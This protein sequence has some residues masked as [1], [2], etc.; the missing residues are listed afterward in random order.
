MLILVVILKADPKS[1]VRMP[2]TAEIALFKEAITVKHSLLVDCYCMV[3]GLKLYL[4]QPGDSIIQTCF[5]NGWKHDY[6]VTT[7][8]AFA[9]NG[10]IIACTLNAPGTWHGST[11]PHWGSMYSKLQKY[12][13]D[14]HGKVLMDSAFASNMYKFIIQSSQNVPIME[15]HQAML[16]GQQA[17]SCR[18]AA[19]WG[20]R[21]LQGSFPRLKDRIV[22][23]ENGERAI[24]LKFMTLLYN[25]RV[26]SVGINQILNHYMPSLSIDARYVLGV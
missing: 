21:G 1:E 14:H 13:E 10:S 19:E 4:Q 16:L 17:T 3:D 26:R 9:L 8:F 12:W 23:E 11:L 7:I 2:D 6:Y 15:G 20:M 22:Y 5:Y 18:Q 25:Y 24:I